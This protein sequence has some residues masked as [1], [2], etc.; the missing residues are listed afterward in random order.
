MK[1]KL[2]LALATNGTS[3]TMELQLAITEFINAVHRGGTYE[4]EVDG[5]YN[6]I[7]SADARVLDTSILPFNA[8]KVRT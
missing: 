5:L 7:R 4:D 1:R 3:E 2:I 8:Q 6:A